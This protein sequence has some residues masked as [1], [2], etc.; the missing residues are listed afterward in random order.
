MCGAYMHPYEITKQINCYSVRKC[1]TIVYEIFVHE[2]HDHLFLLSL[3]LEIF[4]C[5]ISEICR[6]VKKHWYNFWRKKFKLSYVLTDFNSF[7]LQSVLKTWS[8]DK[9]TSL[10][11]IEFNRKANMT[12]QN[13]ILI[14]ITKH[15]NKK[16]SK[17][18]TNFLPWV[19]NVMEQGKSGGAWTSDRYY[20]KPLI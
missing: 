8:K 7:N 13:N 9:N 6:G 15:L 18:K 19:S 20:T 4:W 1:Q 2:V 12:I 16:L 3:Y 14:I 5:K 10:F 17:F 11:I